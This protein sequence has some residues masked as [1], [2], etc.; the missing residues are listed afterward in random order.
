[1]S[2][3]TEEDRQ[4][5]LAEHQARDVRRAA[6]EAEF[7]KPEIISNAD[8][9]AAAKAAQVSLPYMPLS[10][11]AWI[12]A[13]IYRDVA[14]W[15]GWLASNTEHYG[16]TELVRVPLPDGRVIGILDLRASM[17]KAEEASSDGV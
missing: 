5:V 3:W 4:R 16:H 17:P 15:E 6:L 11:D 2:G 8:A 12:I 13:H 7:G 14:A 1:M 10:H 9:I